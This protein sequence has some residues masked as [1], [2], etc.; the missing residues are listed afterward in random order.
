[1][2][3]QE[4]R[5]EPNIE[6]IADGFALW[7][8]HKPRTLDDWKEIARRFSGEADSLRSQL[9]DREQRLREAEES[10]ERVRVLH[11]GVGA[12]GDIA[13]EALAALRSG[14]ANV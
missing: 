9:E 11:H 4:D 1:M 6:E 7:Q 3:H 5:E 13:R 2:A 12:A 8:E 14:R 10:F